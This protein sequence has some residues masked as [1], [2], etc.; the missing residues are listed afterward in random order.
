MA[1]TIVRLANSYR[2]LRF[3]APST[4]IPE[5]ITKLALMLLGLLRIYVRKMVLAESDN[6]SA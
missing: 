2:R 4:T 1:M 6:C 3:A 5:A